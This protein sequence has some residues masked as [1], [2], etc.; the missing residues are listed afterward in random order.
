[1]CIWPCGL[2]RFPLNKL[3]RVDFQTWTLAQRSEK[4]C[5]AHQW[6]GETLEQ[7]DGSKEQNMCGCLGHICPFVVAVSP[8]PTHTQPT[9]PVRPAC[10]WGGP[11]AHTPGPGPQHGWEHG[12][13][14]GAARGGGGGCAAWGEGP[15]VPLA[16]HPE[17]QEARAGISCHASRALQMAHMGP[18][19]Q[20]AWRNPCGHWTV[21]GQWMSS[22]P[23]P[24]HPPVSTLEHNSR[25]QLSSSFLLPADSS[26]GR[27]SV[28]HR[29][30]RPIHRPHLDLP[31]N[32]SHPEQR[33]DNRRVLIAPRAIICPLQT[34]EL[35][36]HSAWR[37][38]C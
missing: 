5:S 2:C 23:A 20:P 16:R 12:A 18:L 38:G 13:W 25:R 17:L 14:A 29:L 4:S 22:G 26:V 7:K 30:L 10:C 3:E 34:P 24:H 37:L 36:P 8:T 11:S 15:A 32:L 21:D 27:G 31:V 33:L 1:M 19:P 9:A 28:A 35:R 6:T